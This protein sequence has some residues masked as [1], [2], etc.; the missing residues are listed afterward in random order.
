M[1]VEATGVDATT[2]ADSVEQE[3]KGT[4]L[5][6]TT[7][8]SRNRGGGISE[9][10]WGKSPGSHRVRKQELKGQEVVVQEENSGLS[11]V[12]WFLIKAKF[13]VWSWWRFRETE[14]KVIG[15]QEIKEQ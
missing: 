11:E 10:D 1:V 9:D 15:L 14:T 5:T 12:G 4:K 3:E 2:Q 8:I 7:G 13:R 6:E